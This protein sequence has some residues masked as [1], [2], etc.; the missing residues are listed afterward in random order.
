[1]LWRCKRRRKRLSAA[2][3]CRALQYCRTYIMIFMMHC[4][5]VRSLWL[6]DFVITEVHIINYLF[7][8]FLVVKESDNVW[9]SWY[10]PP[11]STNDRFHLVLFAFPWTTPTYCTLQYC[12]VL[13]GSV[14][15]TPTYLVLVRFSNDHLPQNHNLIHREDTIDV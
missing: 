10:L 15:T 7:L 14:M 1:M 13:Y 5:G 4:G 9:A 6:Q 12:T 2:R 3:C 8:Y 11:P